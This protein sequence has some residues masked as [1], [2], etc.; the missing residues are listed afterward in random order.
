MSPTVIDGGPDRIA[1]TRQTGDPR[2][3][4]PGRPITEGHGIASGTDQ[5]SRASAVRDQPGAISCPVTSRPP[6]GPMDRRSGPPPETGRDRAA[7]NSDSLQGPRGS[8]LGKV[9]H[10]G[11]VSYTVA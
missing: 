10:G 5:A 1:S 7:T 2:F 3:D 11:P 9:P 4:D 8:F 6:D